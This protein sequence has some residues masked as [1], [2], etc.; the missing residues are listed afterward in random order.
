MAS[1][2]IIVKAPTMEFAANYNEMSLI[3]SRWTLAFCV[4]AFNLIG[5]DDVN[6]VV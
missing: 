5:R 2:N 6:Y 1:N 3:I 4:I